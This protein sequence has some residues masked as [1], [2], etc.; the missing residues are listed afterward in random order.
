MIL[1]IICISFF[2]FCVIDIIF[3]ALSPH[4]ER[5]EYLSYIP[6]SGVYCYFKTKKEK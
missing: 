4:P 3:Y 1:T 2:I 6:G 5:K